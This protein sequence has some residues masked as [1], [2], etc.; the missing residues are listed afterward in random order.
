MQFSVPWFCPPGQL[1]LPLF[2]P[3][4]SLQ[5]TSIFMIVHNHTDNINHHSSHPWACF[6]RC[7]TE[8][9]S[10]NISSRLRFE[11]QL[12]LLHPLQLRAS[13]LP[14][15]AWLSQS[16]FSWTSYGWDSLVFLPLIWPWNMHIIETKWKIDSPRQTNL[17]HWRH[18]KWWHF[19]EQGLPQPSPSHSRTLPMRTNKKGTSW[20]SAWLS[21][22]PAFCCLCKRPHLLLFQLLQLPLR[23]KASQNYFVLA[24][25]SNLWEVFTM[26]SL[27]AGPLPC[28]LLQPLS[29]LPATNASF[30]ATFCQPVILQVSSAV[31]SWGKFQVAL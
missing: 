9:F 26:I 2:R 18:M 21:S 6:Q 20:K 10:K 29:Q 8:Q 11:P 25:E 12:C 4:P 17:Q 14:L 7:I 1:F 27:R 13:P 30:N 5:Q 3:F 19:K 16:T 23:V 15:S 28:F 22:H 24:R 31:N